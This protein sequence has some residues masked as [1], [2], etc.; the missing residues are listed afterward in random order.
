LIITYIL[1]SNVLNCDKFKL[2][3]V[4]EIIPASELIL[5][6]DG[7]IYH[8]N[9]LPGEIGDYIITVG[10]PDRVDAVAKHFDSV[11]LEKTNREFKTVTGRL[12]NKSISVI[13]TGISTDNIDIF[14][15]ELDALVNVDFEK[16]QVKPEH[17]SLNIIRIGT[18]GTIQKEMPLDSFLLSH[19]AIGF[20]GL[21]NFYPEVAEIESQ[22]AK[23]VKQAFS[24]FQPFVFEMD[25]DLGKHFSASFL[26][27]I[28]ATLGGFYA[29]QGRAIRLSRGP[30][31]WMQDLCSF[32]TNGRNI[33]NIEMETA[34]IYGLSKMLGHRAISLNA[35]LANRITGEFSKNPQKTINDLIVKSLSIVDGIN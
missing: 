34:G 1:L 19:F 8:L 10:D 33:T 17:T 13:S 32:D 4:L 11:R 14:L 28:T 9:L 16:R 20:D 2:N 3:I 7:S 29:P 24:N 25:H 35:I 22:L 15:N 27:G 23:E 21:F 6:K 26:F 18:S 12:G 30:H 5:N 31:N